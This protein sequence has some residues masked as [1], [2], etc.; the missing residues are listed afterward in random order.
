MRA[1]RRIPG[2]VAIGLLAFGA[3][4]CGGGAGADGRVA[5]LSG[6]SATTTTTAKGGSRQDFQDALLSYSRCMRQHGVD[7]PDPVFSEDGSG[8]VM[9]KIEG[10]KGG[11]G[12]DSAT[13]KAAGKACQPIMDK[14]EQDMPRP[15]PE[16][17]AKM[18][19]QALA[20]ARCMRDHGVDMPDPTFDG[21]GHVRIEAHA[22]AQAGDGPGTVGPP[23]ADPKFDAAMQAC[24]KDG[25]IK[26]STSKGS[27]S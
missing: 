21:D 24:A 22:S 7:M 18:R 23:K 14:A 16:D 4:A 9:Q 2:I 15:S 19:D 20:F 3:A 27:D 11:P 8:G 5:T 12:P 10:G 25:P 17:E 6:A 1:T 13:F 26:P